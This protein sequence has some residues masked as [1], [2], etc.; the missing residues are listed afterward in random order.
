M[1]YETSCVN[2]SIQ[3]QA[4]KYA[5][6][7][8]HECS[9]T[10]TSCEFRACVDQRWVE[11]C[12]SPRLLKAIENDLTRKDK[13]IPIQILCFLYVFNKSDDEN[14][15]DRYMV[16][17]GLKFHEWVQDV[18]KLQ[19]GGSQ[20]HAHVLS[21]SVFANGMDLDFNSNSSSSQIEYHKVELMPA[22]CTTLACAPTTSLASIYRLQGHTEHTDNT[23]IM[24]LTII[25][26][27]RPTQ[28]ADLYKHLTAR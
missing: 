22:L 8:F 4:E 13:S 17:A 26:Y 2:T 24:A 21:V 23:I 18:V 10:E 5:A 12:A 1:E 25:R 19:L 15:N 11:A 27:L 3:A 14:E 20:T 6:V 28:Q 16:E 9:F 7:I